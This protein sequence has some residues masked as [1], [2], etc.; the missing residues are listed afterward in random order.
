MDN[1]TREKYAVLADDAQVG[2][3]TIELVITPSN[4]V[5]PAHYGFIIEI[6]GRNKLSSS[7]TFRSHKRAW[8][9]MWTMLLCRVKFQNELS[10]VKVSQSQVNI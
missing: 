2:V 8:D 3:V 6:D 10:L 4:M 9:I 5:Y 1:K 7:V